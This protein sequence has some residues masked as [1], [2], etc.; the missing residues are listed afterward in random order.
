VRNAR[1]S[2]LDRRDENCKLSSEL[3]LS[4]RSVVAAFPYWLQPKGLT[5]EKQANTAKNKKRTTLQNPDLPGEVE[6]TGVEP[7]TFCMPC[8]RSSQLS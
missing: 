7:V 8:K 2:N 5:L 6:V 1:S 4:Q 3:S